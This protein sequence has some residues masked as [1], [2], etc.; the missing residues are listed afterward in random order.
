MRV[1]LMA[2]Q[3]SLRMSEES[4]EPSLAACLVQAKIPGARRH[5]FVCLGP[6]CCSFSEGDRLWHHIKRRIHEHNIPVL[7]TKAQC[8]RICHG[9]PW[10]VVY[11]EGAW[12]GAVSVERF[13]RILKE[14]LLGGVVV[15]EWVSLRQELTP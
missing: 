7:R 11:P 10:I 4:V 13:D 1:S 15:S 9:G 6:D 2:C 12:Y 8:F 5:L 14:H 3:R